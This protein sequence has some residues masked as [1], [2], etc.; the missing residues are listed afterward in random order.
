MD[1]GGWVD[2]VMK[3]CDLLSL[4][5]SLLSLARGGWIGMGASG[6]MQLQLQL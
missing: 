4:F 6:T 1:G 3:I 2:G 5:F